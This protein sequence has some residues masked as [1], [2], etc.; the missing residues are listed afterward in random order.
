MSFIEKITAT[1]TNPKNAMKSI[2]EQPMI[3]EAVMIVGIYAVLSALAAYVQS[4][5]LTFVFEGF[6]NI[7]SSM[8]S[9][10]T[11]FGVVGAL[12]NPFLIW[13]IGT[14]IIHLISMALGGE[15]K[16]Y[17]QMMTV[18]G[19]S[20]VPMFFASII[21][22]ALLFMVE[23]MTITISAANP[24]AAKEIYNNPFFSASTIIGT[25]MQ[26]WAA[27]I[28]FFGVQSAHR[29]THVKS[30]VVAGVPLL[31]NVMLALRN[32]SIL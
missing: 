7:P 23:P 32:L 13:L 19:Y 28:I 24:M 11:I 9:L 17:P 26:I 22:L 27:V 29:L 8:Q 10:T 2:G 16:F 15:G 5:K 6:E 12:I 31:I 3:E 30:A 14:G 4:Y 18:I 1:I 21:S 20:M 25:I